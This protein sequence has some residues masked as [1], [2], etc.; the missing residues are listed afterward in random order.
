V[1]QAGANIFV[2]GSGIFKTPNYQKTISQMKA[3][4]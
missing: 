4:L 2:S 1:A 3:K